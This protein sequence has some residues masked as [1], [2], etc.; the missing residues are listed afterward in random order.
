[1]QI[2]RKLFVCSYWFV[3]IYSVSYFSHFHS[4]RPNRQLLLVA[5]CFNGCNSF[6]PAYY[7]RCFSSASKQA[8]KRL[9]SS[10]RCLSFGLQIY[11][12]LGKELLRLECYRYIC[13]W[14]FKQIEFLERLQYW[15]PGLMMCLVCCSR[16]IFLWDAGLFHFWW[17]H[18]ALTIQ[19]GPDSWRFTCFL[20]KT[21]HCRQLCWISDLG[22]GSYFACDTECL[23]LT[24]YLQTCSRAMGW[25]QSIV[26]S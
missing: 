9:R 14:N 2:W 23:C 21:F 6:E 12:G 19:S 1:M 26:E 16:K 17:D 13:F 10:S 18:F 11:F 15:R 22:P 5:L 20:S 3:I 4:S 7:G 8:L 24:D 25:D